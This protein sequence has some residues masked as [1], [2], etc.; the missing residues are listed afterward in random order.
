MINTELLEGARMSLTTAVTRSADAATPGDAEGLATQEHVFGAELKLRRGGRP[1]L[2]R[3]LE[4]VLTG[5]V[6]TDKARRELREVAQKIDA[7][8]APD[9]STASFVPASD[10]GDRR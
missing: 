6:T 10:G 3:R 9:V 8:L 2:A 5:D 4:A 7:E 1:D